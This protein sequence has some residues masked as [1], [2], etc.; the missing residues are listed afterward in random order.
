MAD[1]RGQPRADVVELGD[2]AGSFELFLAQLARVLH[3][4]ER[5]RREQ[6]FRRVQLRMNQVLGVSRSTML[7]LDPPRRSAIVECAVGADGEELLPEGTELG[8]MFPV[9]VERLCTGQMSLWMRLPED[10]PPG[11][12]LERRFIEQ[13]G[14]RSVV[15]LPLTVGGELRWG[16]ALATSRTEAPWIRPPIDRIR[17]VGQLMA[18]ALEAHRAREALATREA[19]YRTLFESAGIGILIHRPD[20]RVLAANECAARLFGTT[21]EE[22]VDQVPW[23]FAVDP[24][25]TRA[26]AHRNIQRALA[27]ETVE[28]EWRG[29]S[30]QGQEFIAEVVLTTAHLDEG[31]AVQVVLRDVTA[32]RRAEERVKRLAAAFEQ[33]GDAVVIA[34]RFGKVDFA[35]RAQRELS[36]SSLQPGT[37][38]FELLSFDLSVEMRAELREAFEKERPW[39]GRVSSSDPEDSQHRDVVVYPIR[40]DDGALSGW[41]SSSR[42]VTERVRLHE[43]LQNARTMEAIGTMA[44][45]IA[46]DFNNLL[47]VIMG[48]GDMA[49]DELGDDHQAASDVRQMLVAAR[50]A[51]RLVRQLLATS[52]RSKSRRS[53]I[54]LAQVVDEVVGA[55]RTTLPLAIEVDWAMPG[56]AV[57]VHADAAELHQVVSNLVENGVKAVE[58][59]GSRIRVSL[60]LVDSSEARP[61]D[62]TLGNSDVLARLQVEDDGLG[63]DDDAIRRC[64]EPF[65]TNRPPGAGTGLG[66]AVVHGIVRGHGGEVR[67][68]SAPGR[69]SR[70]E[71]LLPLASQND[72]THVDEESARH[73]EVGRVLVVDDEPGLVGVAERILRS[74]GLEVETFTDGTK[75]IER[76]ETGG[77]PFEVVVTDLAMQ[78]V[79]GLQVIRALRNLRPDVAVVLVSGHHEWM[80]AG[81]LPTGVVLLDKPYTFETLTAAVRRAAG[82]RADGRA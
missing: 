72:S 81:P 59:Q 2:G 80:A 62:T 37:D 43:R 35:N 10:I 73:F 36:L 41:F 12:D 79:D 75:L 30:R 65:Y 6:A 26:A 60:D 55:A 29:R 16:L 53:T 18:D 77:P 3:D 57:A 74:A 19:R 82:T 7:R 23:D 63:M 42:D 70:F 49:L 64:F 25:T 28:F 33:S 48:H 17:V 13:A 34:D 39:S 9:V 15:L 8:D 56:E 51:S 58:L 40:D 14:L 22:L 68:D 38:L 71:V 32:R 11:A 54:N 47:G 67:V 5:G 52:R 78:G 27:G 20:A 66:L 76:V 69:G 24:E 21:P 46:H 31:V 44:G 4:P 1:S 50:R 45:G 61:T